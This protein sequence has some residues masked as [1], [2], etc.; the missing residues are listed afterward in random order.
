MKKV[1]LF[2]CVVFSALCF[3]CSQESI[4]PLQEPS[5]FGPSQEARLKTGEYL[6]LGR[7]NPLIVIKKG[8]NVL[9]MELKEVSPEDIASIQVLKNTAATEAYGEAGK[10]GVIIIELK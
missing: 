2:S 8:E 10:D 1:I 3:A 4:E 6:Q 9:E 7:K 5:S